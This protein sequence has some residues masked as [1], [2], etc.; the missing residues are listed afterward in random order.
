MH[1]LIQQLIASGPVLIDG[2]WGTRLQLQELTPGACA[3]GWNLSHPQQVEQLAREYVEAGSRVILT[4]TFRANRLTLAP[5]G[6]ADCV[7]EI[8]RSGVAISRRAAAGKA[9]VFASIG[10]SG[11]L[12][13]TGEVTERELRDV[14]AEQAQVLAAAGADGLVVE[15]MCD[16][17]EA[18]IALE[19]AQTTG[20]PVVVCMVFD[21]GKDQDRTMMG[22]TPEQV[23]KALTAAGAEVIGANCGSGV[24]GYVSV[25]RRIRAATDRPIWIKPNAGLP[26]IV[27]G[28]VVYRM[29]PQEFA[30][31][32][33]ALSEAGAN[34]IGGCCGTDPAFIQ[35]LGERLRDSRHGFIQEAGKGAEPE[36]A[37]SLNSA[38][39]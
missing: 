33:A 32:A 29:T 18:T 26:E 6:L 2:A 7:A 17:D 37:C 24:S 5:R 38:H 25:C 23:T 12:L 9:L 28:R 27:D 36:E 30:G 4:N 31:Q 1:S 22:R 10:P 13:I 16:L 21:S 19:A 11:K 34:F 39:A 3:D 14:F 20:L 8:N 15:T 35:A